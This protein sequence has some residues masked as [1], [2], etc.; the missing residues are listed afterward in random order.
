MVEV[1][2]GIAITRNLY[3]P[4]V[5]KIITRLTSLKGNMDFLLAILEILAMFLLILQQI[6]F[7]QILFH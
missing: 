2:V 4:I 3:V 5:E 6:L 7:Q 1:E